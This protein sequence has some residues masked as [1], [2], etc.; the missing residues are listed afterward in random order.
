MDEQQA[1]YDDFFGIN[2]EEVAEEVI[3]E[4]NSTEE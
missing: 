1:H 2:N 3:E 4:N